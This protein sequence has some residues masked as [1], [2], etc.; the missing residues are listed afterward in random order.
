MISY[1]SIKMKGIGKVK[2][3]FDSIPATLIPWD[4]KLIF[5]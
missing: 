3:G 1:T 5:K 4:R 2:M